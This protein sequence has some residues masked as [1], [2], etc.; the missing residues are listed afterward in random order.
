[1]RIVFFDIDN[2]IIDNHSIRHKA[3]A[4]ALECLELGKTKEE[5]MPLYEKVV[6]CGFIF[7][8][9]ELTNFIHIWN[10]HDL[11]AV[12][13]I[14][15]SQNE[16]DYKRL[17]MSKDDQ[18]VFIKKIEELK[19]AFS[20]AHLD[21]TSF[22][23]DVYEDFKKNVLKEPDVRR[24]L[25]MV[26]KIR[27]RPEIKKA[28]KIFRSSL[29]LVPAPGFIHL[30]HQLIKSGFNVYFVSEGIEKIQRQKLKKLRLLKLFKQRLI[31]TDAAADTKAWIQ[32][33]K[34][35]LRC[36]KRLQ[37]VN[38]SDL[39]RKN[40]TQKQKILRF[41]ETLLEAYSAKSNPFFYARVIHAVKQNQKAPLH[42]LKSFAYI[43]LTWWYM[44][45][46]I[47]IAVI[48]DRYDKD[49]LPLIQLSGKNRIIS[50]LY[51]QGKYKRTFPREN[52]IS[53]TSDVP[54][55]FIV[56]DFKAVKD[57]LF[58]SSLWLSREL[59]PYSD[60]IPADT[61]DNNNPLLL[62]SFYSIRFSPVKKI[63]NIAAKQQ[64]I[65]NIGNSVYQQESKKYYL[66]LRE[67]H[68]AAFINDKERIYAEKYEKRYDNGNYKG[69]K[70][71]Y[72]FV[73]IIVTLLKNNEKVK[74][75]D[76][77]CGSHY[78]VHDL[79]IRYKWD[80]KGFDL[81][82][83]AIQMAK[84]NYSESKA[85]YVFLNLLDNML[86]VKDSSQD[87]VFCNA[88]I[89]HFDNIE[90]SFCLQDISR[91]LKPGGMFILIFKWN[92]KNWHSF[93]EKYNN[94]VNVLDH[95]E[96][97]IEIEDKKMK[98]TLAELP[99]QK[100]KTINPKYFSGMRLF[101]FF[102][103]D[104]ILKAAK[105]YH[106]NVK[107][108]VNIPGGDIGVKGIFTYQSGKGIPTC[109]IIFQKKK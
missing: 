103:I 12:I 66:E 47:Q 81:D 98:Q 68:S 86:P 96:G 40:L 67:I 10:S 88:V 72:T 8:L 77:G 80:V 19:K 105:H 14:L 25:Q 92:I 109:T 7:E 102:S 73:N 41:T 27:N 63:M 15:Y 28:F 65:K 17:C 26:K 74:G 83:Y 99:G 56:E 90:L 30:L 58:D 48:G 54:P 49:I 69:I 36:E 82:K 23:R 71:L 37:S 57:I 21:R 46:P 22:D 34:M 20:D 75:I 42:R 6:E 87:F 85:N 11:Y 43:P 16:T 78:L 5:L 29:R 39:N 13:K 108:K 32:I 60:I 51:N 45:P 100:K 64:E 55:D 4:P 59:V 62:K 50:I 95:K 107:D 9:M 18:A 104:Y 61:G 94:K 52:H 84:K 38:L 24:F 35:R 70:N 1:M 44:K 79:H 89:Q 33:K 53:E 91:V 106:F 97:K 76:Y 3:M 2:T 31:T 93:E 101:H